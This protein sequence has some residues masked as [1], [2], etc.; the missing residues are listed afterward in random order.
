MLMKNHT[1]YRIVVADVCETFR[2]FGGVD[3]NCNLHVVFSSRQQNIS[4]Q[5]SLQLQSCAGWCG[6]ILVAKRAIA[7]L[8]YLSNRAK[9]FPQII[10][11]YKSLYYSL[12]AQPA[13]DEANTTCILQHYMPTLQGT[14]VCVY[15]YMRVCV[16]FVWVREQARQTVL[17]Y[18]SRHTIG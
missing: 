5:F 16:Y 17:C 3:G 4:C 6:L 18:T 13:Y 8:R 14:C 7:N 10:F 11:G 2:S 12:R 15:L 9:V 1:S